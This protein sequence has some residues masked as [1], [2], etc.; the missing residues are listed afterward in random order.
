[1]TVF[2]FQS[3]K[4]MTT[5]G[6]GGMITTNDSRMAH[7][8]RR[9]RSF[10]KNQHWGTNCKM[11]KAQAAVGLVQLRR[12]DEMNDR[13]IA[14]ARE[15]TTLLEDVPSLTLPRE[16]KGYKHLYYRY[17]ILAPREWRGSRRD[18]LINILESEFGVGCIVAD[19]QTYAVHPLIREHVEGQKCPVTD[20]VA[21]RLFCPSLHPL[22]T[23]EENRYIS[24]AIREATERLW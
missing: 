3:K 7:R 11:T 21:E 12:L 20:E 8:L 9:L 5:L 13:R 2:S 24:A 19:P 22:M 16:P 4:L 18:R 14:L 1:M 10:G 6:E 15:R 17:S 23:S